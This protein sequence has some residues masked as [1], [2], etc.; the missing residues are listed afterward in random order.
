MEYTRTIDYS[1][2]LS[3]FITLDSE[4]KAPTYGSAGAAGCDVYALEGGTIKPNK[5]S[6]IPTGIAMKIPEGYYCEIK[7]R[8]GLALKYGL[9]VMAGVIDCDFRGHVQII[10][11]NSGET[12]FTYNKHD[13]IAQFIFKKY[14]EANF[15]ITTC[16]PT[17]QRGEGG[18]GSSGR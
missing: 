9:M 6:M 15:L 14:E 3:V 12:D 16:L 13:R 10:L 4:A 7:P 17:S 8:S 11:H 5:R 18:F 2:K 1:G